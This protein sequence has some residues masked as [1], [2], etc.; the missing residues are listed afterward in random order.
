MDALRE[1]GVV[2][3]R[4]LAWPGCGGGA[5]A[6]APLRVGV[7][8]PLEPWEVRGYYSAAAAAARTGRGMAGAE[9][10]VASYFA[11]AG[12]APAA[13]RLPTEPAAEPALPER[14]EVPEAW[15]GQRGARGAR[16]SDVHRARPLVKT[17]A[18]PVE[19]GRLLARSSGPRAASG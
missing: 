1:K 15:A 17:L 12:P 11:G 7:P 5:G 19:A 4:H 9:P 14:F 10:S 3:R 8:P 2:A 16:R 6:P 18:R 13:A